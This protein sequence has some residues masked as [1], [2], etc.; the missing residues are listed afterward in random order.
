LILTH[1][2]GLAIDSYVEKGDSLAHQKFGRALIQTGT[3]AIIYKKFIHSDNRSA[4]V[5]ADLRYLGAFDHQRKCAGF[6]FAK[7]DEII[8]G[9]VKGSY[10]K[11]FIARVDD[12]LFCYEILGFDDNLFVKKKIRILRIPA[13]FEVLIEEKGFVKYRTMSGE[14]KHL[15]I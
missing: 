5:F 13:D 15:K 8:T 4:P 11:N 7:P 14:V 3:S 2:T 1:D 12:E 10:H 6:Q 9:R